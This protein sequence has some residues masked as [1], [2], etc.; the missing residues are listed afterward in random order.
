MYKSLWNFV[1]KHVKK[2]HVTPVFLVA[3]TIGWAAGGLLLG[4][5]GCLAA[6]NA[7]YITKLTLLFCTCGYA[8]VI[9]GFLG[10][11]FYLYRVTFTREPRQASSSVKIPQQR[12]S[13]QY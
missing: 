13:C 4:S 2:S 6:G 5:I 11:I 7:T 10:G 1:E 3:L 8:A 12:K 9:P